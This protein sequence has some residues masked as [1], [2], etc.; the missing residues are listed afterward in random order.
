MHRA[1]RL[2]RRILPDVLDA[3]LPTGC[4]FLEPTSPQ[5]IADTVSWGVPLWASSSRRG[6]HP[7]CA[8]VLPWSVFARSGALSPVSWHDR[9]MADRKRAAA[10]IIRDGRL[11]MVRERG[12]GPLGLHDGQEYWTVPGG[13]IEAGE[14]PEHAVMR[15]VVE[16]VGLEPLTARFLYDV[17][18]P[19]G[20]TACFRVWVAPGEPRLGVDK[21]LRCGCPRMV[22]LSWIPLPR[23]SSAPESFMVPTLLMA[24]PMT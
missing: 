13:G 14:T 6:C 8:R 4:E 21:D 1:L 20:W 18:F 7:G 17:P 24:T 2:A 10:V 12:T 23:S 3:G 15:E 11:L 9:P 19:S 5:Y 22:G 16:E